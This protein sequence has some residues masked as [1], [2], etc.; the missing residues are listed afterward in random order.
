MNSNNRATGEEHP[1]WKFFGKTEFIYGKPKIV[2]ADQFSLWLHY[3]SDDKG[4]YYRVTLYAPAFR[5]QLAGLHWNLIDPTGFP[6]ATGAF[7]HR[8]E[9]RIQLDPANDFLRGQTCQFTL[10]PAIEDLEEHRDEQPAVS[11]DSDDSKV[12]LRSPILSYVVP[13]RPPLPLDAAPLELG[14]TGLGDDDSDKP[15]KGAEKWGL[16]RNGKFLILDCSTDEKLEDE[17][18]RQT[19]IEFPFG[20]AMVRLYSE[21]KKLIGEGLIP[22]GQVGDRFIARW[23]VSRILDPNEDDVPIHCIDPPEPVTLANINNVKVEWVEKLIES[24]DSFF[25]M[26]RTIKA[27]LGQLKQRLEETRE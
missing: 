5:D 26:Y 17:N 8:P 23:P 1:F 9:F 4:S 11:G 16:T 10:T 22:V 15:A 27:Q 7:G 14:A 18:G 24:D 19:T 20:V 6:I 12:V 13:A 25:R 2:G 21:H 3:E